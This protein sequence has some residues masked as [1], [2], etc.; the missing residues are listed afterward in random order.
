MG[1][2]VRRET[3]GLFHLLLRVRRTRGKGR[4]ERRRELG[5]FGPD[6]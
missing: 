3:I 1:R 6:P 2:R 4:F 5:W